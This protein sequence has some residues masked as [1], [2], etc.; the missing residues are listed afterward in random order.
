MSKKI[1]FAEE[2]RKE[3]KIGVDAVANAVKI[4]LGP[5]GRNVEIDKG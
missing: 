5:S 2:A 3:I 4:T 1:L